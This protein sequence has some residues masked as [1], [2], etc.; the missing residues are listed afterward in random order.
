MEEIIRFRRKATSHLFHGLWILF[1]IYRIWDSEPPGTYIWGL[2]VAIPIALILRVLIKTNYLEI[3]DSRLTINGD[4]FTTQTTEINA[5]ERIQIE[6]GPWEFKNI[7]EGQKENYKI[8][9]SE[10]EQ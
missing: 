1:A 8:Q 6:A 3:K 5:I 10:R 9:L 2:L 4:F 7:F